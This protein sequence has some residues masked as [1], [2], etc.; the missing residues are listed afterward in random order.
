M[1]MA[2]EGGDPLANAY[3][4]SDSNLLKSGQRFECGGKRDTHPSGINKK[5]RKRSLSSLGNSRDPNHCGRFSTNGRRKCMESSILMKLNNLHGKE[6]GLDIKEKIKKKSPDA[7]VVIE[8]NKPLIGEA[9]ISEARRSKRLSNQTIRSIFETL[10]IGND[11]NISLFLSA[12]TPPD[13]KMQSENQGGRNKNSIVS[14]WECNRANAACPVSHECKNEYSVSSDR[15]KLNDE[16]QR[17]E[18]IDHSSHYSSLSSPRKHVKRVDKQVA[19]S[20]E[21]SVEKMATS[22]SSRKAAAKKSIESKKFDNSTVP[23]ESTINVELSS[24][25]NRNATQMAQSSDTLRR[26]RRQIFPV[27]RL[28]TKFKIKRKRRRCRHGRKKTLMHSTEDTN[29][30]VLMNT[31]VRE[32]GKCLRRS[33]R[34]RVPI[35]R[36]TTSFNRSPKGY[37]SKMS[38]SKGT[39]DDDKKYMKS[40]NKVKPPR[41]K[42]DG[43]QSGEESSDKAPQVGG[44]CL[45]ITNEKILKKICQPSRGIIQ[46]QKASSLENEK[47][48][49]HKISCSDEV[50]ASTPGSIWDCAE[51]EALRHA[52]AN[53]NPMSVGFWRDVATM[54]RSKSAEECRDKWFSMAGTPT[55]N[56]NVKTTSCGNTNSD[57]EDD[58]FNSTPIRNENTSHRLLQDSLKIAGHK[59]RILFDIFS[60]PMQMKRKEAK[61]EY[62]KEFESSSLFLPRIKSYLREVGNGIRNNTLALKSSKKRRN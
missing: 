35:Q 17:N 24:Q 53:T 9:Q 3:Y 36:F 2:D 10:P 54:V 28:V 52:H 18:K 11:P 27:D 22:C 37:N 14:P 56:I 60:S 25:E 8:N 20:K 43:N 62:D 55:R 12:L 39:F 41:K 33:T 34:S 30:E 59:N 21:A 31:Q 61:L 16:G 50:N 19:T 32:E 51:L 23:M 15:N 7:N 57:G 6:S 49:N 58:I 47:L 29:Q 13:D 1:A 48:N 38:S 46:R 42:Y 5:K 26:T 4:I 45:E 44:K 40:E